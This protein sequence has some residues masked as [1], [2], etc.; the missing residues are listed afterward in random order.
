MRCRRWERGNGRRKNTE[1]KTIKKNEKKNTI[2]KEGRENKE[3]KKKR[4][5][6]GKRRER[7]NERRKII[8][9]EIKGK[10]KK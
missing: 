7:V 3:R 10:E 4:L 9:M 1:K 8:I 6:Y 2:T 5:R